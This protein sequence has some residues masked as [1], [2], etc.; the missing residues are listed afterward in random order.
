MTEHGV[1]LLVVAAMAATVAVWSLVSARFERWNV[2]APMFFVML[3]LLLANEPLEL[4]DI[5]LGSEG[6]RTMAE[7]T[8]AVVLFGDAAG[9]RVRDLR[10]DAGLPSRLLL[11]GLP[12]TIVAGTIAARLAL[13]DLSWWVCAVIGAAVAPTDAALGAAIIEDR[14]IPGRIRRLLNVESG[15]N[16]G[17]ATPFVNVFIVAAVAGTAFER[18]TGAEAAGELLLGAVGGVVVGGGGAWLVSRARAA[19]F[20]HTREATIATISLALLSFAALVELGGNGFVAAFVAG[21][22][23]GK[24]WRSAM[25]A[26]DASSCEAGGGDTHLEGARSGLPGEAEVL[27]FTHRSSALMSWVVWFL[28]GAVMVPV[29]ADATWHDWLFAAAALTVVRMVPVALALVG[30]GLDRATVLVVGW[31]GPRGLASVVFALLAL[32][33]LDPSD[34]R[35][36]VAAI[37]ATVLA[38]VVAHGV[39]AGPISRRYG[40][41]HPA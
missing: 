22:A 26:A 35:R 36:T 4:I 18:G 24:V 21:L 11:I 31:F 7:L 5:G 33:S 8:L 41:S 6:V 23:F 28:F 3:G 39:S 10:H 1:D 40:T 38:S 25:A 20:T 15:L 16:D 9:V 32:A 19:A 34:G 17:I 27:E 29:L 13:P 14:R 37:T 12:I 30:S 2:S